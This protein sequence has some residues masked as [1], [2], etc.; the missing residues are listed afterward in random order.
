MVVRS[1]TSTHCSNPKFSAK[2]M[3]T[4]GFEDWERTKNIQLLNQVFRVPD[5]SDWTVDG[6]ELDLRHAPLIMTE[7]GCNANTKT[8]STPPKKLQDKL[9]LNGRKRSILKREDATKYRSACR[10]LSY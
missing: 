2:D 10:K 8:V 6:L 1:I 4:L 9:V 7:S 5:R 3:G